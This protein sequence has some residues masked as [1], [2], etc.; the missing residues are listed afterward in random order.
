MMRFSSKK[1]TTQTPSSSL[2][3]LFVMDGIVYLDKQQNQFYTVA[4]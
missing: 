3:M 1:P 2:K 4:H